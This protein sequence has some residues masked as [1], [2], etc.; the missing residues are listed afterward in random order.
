MTSP[1]NGVL[2][3]LF[4]TGHAFGIT[5]NDGTELL[6]HIGI[7]TVN[8]KGKGFNVL[9]KQGD[10]VLA[11]QPIIKVDR[12]LIKQEGYDLTTMLV[13]TNKKDIALKSSGKVKQGDNINKEV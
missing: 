6:V 5:T 8:L 4:P 11:G 1:A 10:H 3:V 12:D 2:S 7:D 9:A 13:V